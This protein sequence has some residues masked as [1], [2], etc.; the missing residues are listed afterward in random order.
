MQNIILEFVFASNEMKQKL[1]Y[2][3]MVWTPPVIVYGLMIVNALHDVRIMFACY[4]F[5][6]RSHIA[7]IAYFAHV[8]FAFLII[9]N[10]K[11][12]FTP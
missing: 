11:T 7:K 2:S 5:K 9:K 3:I 1:R 4:V 8:P 12:Y 10:R 6:L